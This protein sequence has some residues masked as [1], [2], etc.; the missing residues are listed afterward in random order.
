VTVQGN[1]VQIATGDS[2]MSAIDTGTTL[3]GGPS[4]DVQNMWAQVPGSAPL[5]GNMAGFFE[6][7]TQTPTI[8]THAGR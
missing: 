4:A 3:V 5:A 6:F 8:A 2:A 7:R 1:K